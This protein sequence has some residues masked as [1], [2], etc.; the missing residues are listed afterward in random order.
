MNVE[1]GSGEAA[2]GKEVVEIDDE[3]GEKSEK[4]HGGSNSGGS[5]RSLAP[6]SKKRPA[7]DLN[8]DAAEGGGEEEEEEDGESTTEVAGGGSYSNNSSTNNNNT[9][10]TEGSGGERTASVR[11]YNRSKMPRLRWTPD[12]HMSFVHA[13]D[14][15]G[16]QARATP[17][18]V[19]QMMN[20][21]G[22]SIAHVKSHLQMYRSKK[23]DDSGQEKSAISSVVTPVEHSHMQRGD[24]FYP[25]TGACQ[26]FRMDSSDGSGLF[27]ARS[28]LELD[29]RLYGLLHRPLP[30]QAF[31]LKNCNLS[32]HQEWAFNQHMASRVSSSTDHGPA[33]GLIHNMVY[34]KDGKPSTSHLFDVR[35]AV[36][37]GGSSAINPPHQLLEHRRPHAAGDNFDW[38]LGTISHPNAKG[39][40]LDSACNDAAFRGWN[41]LNRHYYSSLKGDAK[42]F[43]ANPRD[44]LVPTD[45]PES[46]FVSPFRLELQ[47]QMEINRPKLTRPVNILGR[48]ENGDPEMKKMKMMMMNRERGWLPNL[49]LSLSPGSAVDP[50]S[51]VDAEE[52]ADS[53]LSLSLSPTMPT[54]QPL[55]LE[56]LKDIPKPSMP[57]R[58]TGSSNR[59]ALGLSTL[60]LTMSIGALE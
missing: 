57:F 3:E 39:V 24:V 12:L 44:P 21:R 14:R 53:G 29:G 1:M 20:V 37:G 56:T 50:K 22:L 11:Q 9:T 28:R 48:R 15:L 32:R 55:S 18:L 8:E 49:Q 58:Q 34:R 35:D 16:G 43:H 19:L 45:S 31:D 13:V 30:H 41:C 36:T 4:S 47:K 40:P 26:P 7:L 25:R 42:Q 6:P 5:S 52:E 60:D 33:K 46:E 2:G 59:A 51:G 23:L 54:R 10:P 17:K 27:G 38:V